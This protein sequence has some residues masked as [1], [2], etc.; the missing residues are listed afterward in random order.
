MNC[1]EQVKESHMVHPH[2]SGVD[3]KS[4]SLTVQIYQGHLIVY[5][6]FALCAAVRSFLMAMNQ[7]EA[8]RQ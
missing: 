1:V 2:S 6:Q 8:L 4:E 5:D 7:R 3:S